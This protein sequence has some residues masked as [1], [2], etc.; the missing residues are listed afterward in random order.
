VSGRGLTIR[1][2]ANRFAI[3]SLAFLTL[4]ACE[5]RRTC[6]CD[7]DIR[8]E[9]KTPEELLSL[10]AEAYERKDADTYPDLLDEGFEF[11]YP[12]PDWGI[13]QIVCLDKAGDVA[14]TLNMFDDP[15]VKSIEVAFA[16]RE[17]WYVC[18][19]DATIGLC[20]LLEPDIRIILG[21]SATESGPKTWAEIKLYFADESGNEEDGAETVTWCVN[22]TLLGVMVVPDRR[23]PD[24]WVILQMGEMPK[25]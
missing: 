5:N 12:E 17:S 15:R 25:Q 9:P 4:A 23:N 14:S 24:Y 10:F 13:P 2:C 18:S 16:W 6:P 8:V 22:K 19:A 1:Q 21:G 20:C 3:V 11:C 7:D